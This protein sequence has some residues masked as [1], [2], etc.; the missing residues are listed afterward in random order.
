MNRRVPT[1]PDATPLSDGPDLPPT[2][3]V[4]GYGRSGT[5]LLNTAIGFHP[6]LAWFSGVNDRYP[7]TPALSMWSRGGNSRWIPSRVQRRWVKGW[8]PAEAY[9]VWRHYFT[10]FWG[11][12]EPL[13]ADEVHRFRRFVRDVTHWQHRTAFL[14]KV[15]AYTRFDVLHEILPGTKIIWISRDPRA[16]VYS[17]M[18]LQWGFRSDPATWAA[19]KQEDR[20]AHAA[21]DFMHI[22]DRV[23]W[24]DPSVDYL[25]YEQLVSDLPGI[26]EALLSE[27]GLDPDPRHRAHLDALPIRGSTNQAW[28]DA[29][30]DSEQALLEEAVQ[31][32]TAQLGY[33]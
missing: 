16:V 21:S 3:I 27:I 30:T 9:G 15:T 1:K 19:M 8:R 2:I 23:D 24:D 10:D 26:V 17:R 33:S 13:P 29:L 14:A 5:T 20:L 32:A 11:L 12:D 28:Q 22:H 18:K 6:E 4:N 31:P 25:T 7:S